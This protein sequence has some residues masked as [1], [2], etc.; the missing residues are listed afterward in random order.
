MEE[1]VVY[2]PKGLFVG[3][4]SY[5]EAQAF[6]QANF[7]FGEWTVEPTYNKSEVKEVLELMEV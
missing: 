7:T 3:F 1:F 6:G 5:E 2:T 4:H